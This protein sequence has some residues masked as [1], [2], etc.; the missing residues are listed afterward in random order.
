MGDSTM[1]AELSP[2]KRHRWAACP[3]SIREEAR[4]PEPPAGDAAVQGTRTHTIL[5][6]AINWEFVHNKGP[7]DLVKLAGEQVHDE[8]GTW[9]VGPERVDRVDV[10]LEYIRSRV[11]AN[12]SGTVPIAETRVFPDGLVGRADL[13]GTIDVQIPGLS[14]YEIIDYKDGMMPVE[15]EWNPQLVQYAI[16]VIAGLPEP[17]PE[18]FRLTIIQ[19]K[20]A[21]KGLDPIT[22]W[23]VTTDELLAQVP[24]I[25]AQAA[26]TEDPNAPLVPG[27][28]QCKYCRAK[29][30]CP[31]LTGMVSD[32]F[33]PVT[34]VVAQPDI[35]TNAANRDPDK[36]SGEE[37][38]KFLDAAPLVE[39][40][41][42]SIREEAQRRLEKGVAVPGYK[43]VQGRG[44]REWTLPEEEMVKKLGP[45]GMN[46]PKGSLYESKFISP[47]KAESLTWE[48]KGE[49]KKLTGIQL[50]RMQT[51]YVRSLPGKSTLAPESDPRPAI[52]KDAS[53]LMG[54]VTVTAQVVP[55]PSFFGPPAATG[56]VCIA[57]NSHYFGAPPD[58]ANAV[59]L[60]IPSWFK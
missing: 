16:G 41:L 9:I 15:A 10:A 4:F 35:A 38:R 1:H 23:D 26:A 53:D 45:G 36:M 28:A 24:V 51:E 2:S 47:A 29:A 5:E 14:L 25:V 12:K 22:S 19:P 17:Y 56:D 40:L 39:S 48:S 57:N 13:H 18:H 7:L 31:A 42:K 30:T 3:G 32:M 60:P 33:G 46:I 52:V 58:P 54:A 20:L 34:T 50:K 27:D 11:L 8:T 44:S 49:M 21:L 43:M 55:L 6:R 59:A 37:L